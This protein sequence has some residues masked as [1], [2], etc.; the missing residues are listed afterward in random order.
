MTNV[1]HVVVGGL[2]GVVMDIAMRSD[3]RGDGCPDGVYVDVYVGTAPSE[4]VHGVIPHYRLRVYLL[5]NH[6]HTLAIE[7][8][9]APRGSRYKD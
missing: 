4:L 2:K 8:A 9:D 7:I 3:K 6:K 1:H 5:E